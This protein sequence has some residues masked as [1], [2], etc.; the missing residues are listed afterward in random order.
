MKVAGPGHLLSWTYRS[1]GGSRCNGA[2]ATPIP[3]PA[4]LRRAYPRARVGRWEYTGL[5]LDD[6]G[7]VHS[8]STE[9]WR[10]RRH[11]LQAPGGPPIP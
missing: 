1:R 5:E 11:Q 4:E 7:A 9:T 8:L 3:V 6:N 2:P 10:E